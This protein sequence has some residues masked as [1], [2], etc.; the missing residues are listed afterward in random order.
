MAQ[1]IPIAQIQ[2]HPLNSNVMS[3]PLLGKLERHIRQSG[4]Y[5]PL[6]VRPLPTADGAGQPPQF[7]I[8]NGHHRLEV[9]RR[10]GHATARCEVWEVDDRETLLLLATLNRLE[11]RDDPLRRAL[12]LSELAN[13]RGDGP[14]RLGPLAQLLPEDRASLERALTLARLKLPVPARPD[15]AA[16]A[17]KPLTFFLRR[18]ELE[19]VNR[20]LRLAERRSEAPPADDP[21]AQAP[22]P[23]RG[24]GRAAA[25]VCL[26]ETFLAAD[27]ER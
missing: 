19:Q 4:R 26:A 20:A 2:P 27:S 18:E 25:L 23:Q 24:R 22:V 8:I 6:I 7:Q 15:E 14:G 13:L 17:F 10:L 3:E 21:A 9:L 5:E 1:E 11:G 16:A 12:L